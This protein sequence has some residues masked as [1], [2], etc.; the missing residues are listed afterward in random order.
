[1]RTFPRIVGI[2]VERHRAGIQIFDGPYI[3][4][5]RG[6]FCDP[7]APTTVGCFFTQIPVLNDA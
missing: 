7:T 3:Q 4:R 6:L 1:M 2:I 5:P